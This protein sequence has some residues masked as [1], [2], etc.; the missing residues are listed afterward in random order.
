MN[1]ARFS[2][3]KMQLQNEFH[4]QLCDMYDFL[5]SGVDA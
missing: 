1:I 4:L 2:L 5:E 3:T